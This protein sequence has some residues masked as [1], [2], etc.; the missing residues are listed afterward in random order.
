MQNMKQGK[1][2]NIQPL[3]PIKIVIEAEENGEKFIA[4]AIM[5]MDQVDGKIY[6]FHGPIEENMKE[7]IGKWIDKKTEE[8]RKK[9]MSG[10]M[11][12]TP[13]Q[14]KEMGIDIKNENPNLNKIII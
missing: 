10:M 1:I 11:Q 3:A 13:Q 9:Q 7:A 12:A 2:I 4:E 5:F 14:L 6:D 8:I